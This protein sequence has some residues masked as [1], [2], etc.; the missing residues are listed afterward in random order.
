[1]GGCMKKIK[2]LIVLIP[3][4]SL[5][6]CYTQLALRSPESR[7]YR[8][9]RY[10]YRDYNDTLAVEEDSLAYLDDQ[11]YYDQDRNYR[12]FYMGYYPSSRFYFSIGTYY[13][14]FWS[15][16]YCCDYRY[17]SPWYNS[18]WYPYY[19]PR[20]YY[21]NYW[22]NSFGWNSWYWRYPYYWNYGNGYY[23][24]PGS[25]TYKY[26]PT[27]LRDT[28][29]RGNDRNASLRDRSGSRTN[30]YTTR[31]GSVRRDDVDL[32]RASVS[33]SRERM[34]V[35][36]RTAKEAPASRDNSSS[37][38]REETTRRQQPDVR[39]ERTTSTP[40]RDSGR[41]TSNSGRSSYDRPSYNPPSSHSSPSYSPPSRSSSESSSRS[42][43]SSSSS[44]SNSGS[45]TRSSGSDRGR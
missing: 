15:D 27:G 12:R 45:S 34:P 24:Y 32:N 41:N 11:Y 25:Y 26:K 43:S 40:T 21:G 14:P 33:R 29:E 1:M 44:S 42:S 28:G 36:P 5:T 17:Y 37:S 22:Y 3:L 4:L 30:S 23:N 35:N 7:D 20:Y 16:W 6:G 9:D 13:D 31:D 8:E 2:L 39:S 19:Y 38:V 18:P 10:A